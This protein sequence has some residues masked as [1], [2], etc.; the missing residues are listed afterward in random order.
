MVWR[1]CWLRSRGDHERCRDLVQEVCIALWLRFGG[2][3]AGATPREERAWVRWVARTTLDHLHRSKSV[4]ERPLTVDIAETLVAT[5]PLKEQE[6]VEH[7]M[8]SFSPEEQRMVRL[9]LEGYRADEIAQLMGL[10]RDVVYQR[11]HRA[12]QKARRVLL[13]LLLLIVATGIAIAVVPQWRQL[14]FPQETPAAIDSLPADRPSPILPTEVSQAKPEV[15]VEWIYEGYG[16]DGYSVTFCRN[17]SSVVYTRANGGGSVRAVMHNVPG[18]LFNDTLIPDSMNISLRRAALATVLATLSTATQAQV[19]HDFQSV[20]PQGD[21]L[22]CTIIDSVLHHVSVC[23]DAYVWLTPSYI[24]YSDTLVIPSTVEHDGTNWTVTALSDSAFYSHNE[25]ESVVIPPTV[26]TIGKLALAST[27]I[28]EL[29]VPDGVDTIGTKAFGLVKNVIYHGT[30][31]GAPWGALTANAYEEEGLFYS[32]NTRTYVTG[33]RPDVTQAL[34]PS[35]VRVIGRYAF[36][37]AA[38]LTTVTLPEGLD[39][40]GNSA[41]DRCSQLGSVVIPSTVKHIGKYAFSSAFKEDGSSSVTIDDA[42]C[43]LGNGVFAYSY[44]GN[45]NLGDCVTTIGSDA[46]SHCDNLDSII[47]P[48]SCTYIAPRAFCYNFFN[49]LKKIHL[50]DNLDTIRDELLHGCTELEEVNIPQSVV[51]IGEMALAELFH[52]TELSLPAGLTYIGP[53]AFGSCTNVSDLVS[54]AS[55]PPQACNNSFDG[56]NSHLLLTVPCHT[57]GAYRSA[58]YWNYFYN[59]N[60]DCN[61]VPEVE[62]PEVSITVTGNRLTV[63]GADDETVR[64]I[65]AA[66]RLV[67]EGPCRG[68]FRV[69]LPNTGVYLVQV[70]DRKAQKIVVSGTEYKSLQREII[71]GYRWRF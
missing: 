45:V 38:N 30:A 4:A 62:M 56:M 26:T 44:M 9:Q 36:W 10:K 22:F 51:Y 54:L 57:E 21:T 14:I 34:L 52:V 19:A 68:A 37:N 32:D 65:D 42:S 16:M 60:E 23:G 55:V 31:L 17:D 47:V 24:R 20:T 58:P 18:I 53:W 41:F 35:S 29:V 13:V 69:T 6:E 33:C 11:M 67:V 15:V 50:P 71:E 27:N 61:A 59:I 2:L 8:A 1:M 43:S 12:V 70:G 63:E 39:T 48:N 28:I 40:I 7:V 5:D 25:I 3:R 66:G 64:V 49:R 46:F